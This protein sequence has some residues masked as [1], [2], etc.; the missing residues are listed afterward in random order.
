MSKYINKVLI[1]NICGK[2]HE[3]NV[4]RA[5]SVFKSELDGYTGNSDLYATVLECPCCH[6][7][8]EDITAEV[9]E[10]EK[11]RGLRAFLFFIRLPTLHLLQ[12]LREHSV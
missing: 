2:S 1:C 8:N 7:V 11:A 9:T 4:L 12:P 5:L 3:Y 10:K 6:N